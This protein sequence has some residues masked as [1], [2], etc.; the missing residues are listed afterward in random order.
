[1]KSTILCEC[2]FSWGEGPKPSRD[3]QRGLRIKK[4]LRTTLKDVNSEK[5]ARQTQAKQESLGV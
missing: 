3:S 5:P 1:M 4:M 2:V